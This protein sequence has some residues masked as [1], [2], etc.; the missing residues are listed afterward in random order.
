MKNSRRDFL[1]KSALGAAGFAVGA[2]K[3]KASGLN[4]VGGNKPP[5]VVFIICDQ[6]R[7]DAMRCVGNPNVHTPNLDKMAANGAIFENCFSNSPV[8]APNRVSAFSGLY[9]HQHGKLTNHSGKFI[10]FKHHFK[11]SMLGY[12]CDQG[13]QMGWIGKNH[14]CTDEVLKRLDAWEDRGREPFRA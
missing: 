11:D 6:M 13:Y 4:G 12:F 3:I 1:K 7:G 10:G 14:T 9:P 8:S 2:H 5:N